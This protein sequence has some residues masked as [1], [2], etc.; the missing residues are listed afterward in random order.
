MK[1]TV[2]MRI[3]RI[4]AELRKQLFEQP[5]EISQSGK[6]AKVVY[7]KLAVLRINKAT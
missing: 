1:I 4:R 2:N 6:S 3:M 7:K 5:K